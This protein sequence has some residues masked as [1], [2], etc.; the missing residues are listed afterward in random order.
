M[1]L[2]P[3]DSNHGDNTTTSWL[4]FSTHPSWGPTPERA[5]RTVHRSTWDIAGI[6]HSIGWSPAMPTSPAI[7]LLVISP[8]GSGSSECIPESIFVSHGHLCIYR[9]ATT[10]RF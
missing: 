8:C 2:C 5:P 6:W 10:G 7:L 4:S 1:S 9:G 3:A